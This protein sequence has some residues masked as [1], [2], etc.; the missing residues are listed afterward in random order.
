MI[1]RA[2]RRGWNA[3]LSPYCFTISPGLMDNMMHAF[4]R[5]RPALRRS[6]LSRSVPAK[7]NI[8]FFLGDE[9]AGWQLLAGDDRGP[10]SP[11][12]EDVKHLWATRLAAP[13]NTCNVA[14]NL[15]AEIGGVVVE[16]DGSARAVVLTRGVD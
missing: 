2:G 7:Q 9:V 1:E 8:R 4:W 14:E 6:Q 5:P 10:F 3:F 16:V 15:V 12:L 13:H 11:G